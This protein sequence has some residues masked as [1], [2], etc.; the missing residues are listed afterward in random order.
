MRTHR[1]ADGTKE[2]ISELTKALQVSETYLAGYLGV[3]EKSLNEWKRLQMGDLT[4]KA[5]RLTRLY[6]VLRYLGRQHE[7]IPV[8]AYKN[9]IENGRVPFD[10]ADE[11]IDSISLLNFILSEPESNYWIACVEQV[12]S[13]YKQQM[14]NA[15]EPTRERRKTAQRFA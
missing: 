15:P 2:M 10:A 3:T 4:P 8:T 7:D 1:E 14:K 6:K 9:L 13:D 5:H 12:V 11:D